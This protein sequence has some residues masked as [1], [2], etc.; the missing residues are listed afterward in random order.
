MPFNREKSSLAR[1]VGGVGDD[2]DDSRSLLLVA[3]LEEY[4]LETLRRPLPIK[5]QSILNQQVKIK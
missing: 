4:G 2:D 5:T 1:G 3:E